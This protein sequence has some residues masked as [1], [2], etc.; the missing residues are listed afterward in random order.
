MNDT[1]KTLSSEHS[2]EW[3]WN[4]HVEGHDGVYIDKGK[5]LW[6]THSENPH[7]SNAAREQSFDDFLKNGP[8]AGTPPS[9]VVQEL[10]EVLM[11]F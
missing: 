1:Q 8:N 6:Y 5:L 10:R 7:A 11:K 9:Q 4:E 3:K 2:Q